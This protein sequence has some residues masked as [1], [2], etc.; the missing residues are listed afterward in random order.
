MQA[1]AHTFEFYGQINIQ[2]G[3][4]SAQEEIYGAKF[5]QIRIQLNGSADMSVSRGLYGV[6]YFH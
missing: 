1:A 5:L 3:I 4:V 2:A 6:K